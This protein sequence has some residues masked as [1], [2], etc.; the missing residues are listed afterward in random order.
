M[1]ISLI[2]AGALVQLQ[3]CGH[4]ALQP[5]NFLL[6]VEVLPAAYQLAGFGYELVD[7]TLEASARCA[8]ETDYFRAQNASRSHALIT[9]ALVLNIG[10]LSPAWV[11]AMVLDGRQANRKQVPVVSDPVGAGATN[12]RNETMKRLLAEVRPAVIRG[13]ASEIRALYYAEQGTKGVDST[14]TS[15]QALDAARALAGA[16]LWTFSFYH[17]GRCTG[18]LA[19]CFD[20]TVPLGLVC[21]WLMCASRRFRV[22]GGIF[23]LSMILGCA[24]ALGNPYNT[25]MWLQFVCLGIGIRFL[26][27]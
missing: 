13:N 1:N 14:H 2:S 12:F 20:Y 24:V 18:H 7:Q 22:G 25:N 3:C 19:I 23:W 9:G 10:T 5:I 16:L 15:E 17:N 4:H 8:A 21:S 6:R 26:R 11:D 27:I